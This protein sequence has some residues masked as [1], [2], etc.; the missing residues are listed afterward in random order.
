MWCL[1]RG[2]AFGVDAF[3]EEHCRL[4]V[5]RSKGCQISFSVVCETVSYNEEMSHL[6]YP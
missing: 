2:R 5:G 6:P 1:E 4:L 3:M